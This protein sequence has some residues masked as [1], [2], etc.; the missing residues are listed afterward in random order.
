[1]KLTKVI[2]YD[3]PATALFEGNIL[4]PT[5]RRNESMEKYSLKVLFL[6]LPYRVKRDV[7]TSEFYTDQLWHCVAP[8]LIK[9][10]A[11]VFLQNM[12]DANT[13]NLKNMMSF[14]YFQRNTAP[15][16]EDISNNI[17]NSNENVDKEVPMLQLNIL[18]DLSNDID[19]YITSETDN[20]PT[21]NSIPTDFNGSPLRD[22][23]GDKCRPEGFPNLANV[24]IEVN[25]NFVFSNVVPNLKDRIQA[26][27]LSDPS[28]DRLVA[29]LIC[30]N[31]QI[32]KSFWELTG[33]QQDVT[34]LEA[35]G[36]AKSIIDWSVK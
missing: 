35:N 2:Q 3:I 25:G 17:Y 13:N 12:Q 28:W 18:A 22:K 9:E 11:Y 19:Q 6:F 1:M 33:Q 29:I 20:E 15:L 31:Q 24:D 10:H 16:V 32:W 4:D 34:V 26:Q 21:Y 27:F 23:V 7:L 8:G 14:D 36:S 30:H 5:T